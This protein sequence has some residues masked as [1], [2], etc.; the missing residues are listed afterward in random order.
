ML[1]KACELQLMSKLFDKIPHCI[2]V[3]EKI[4][5]KYLS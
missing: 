3:Y 4:A 5:K 1:L 2:K